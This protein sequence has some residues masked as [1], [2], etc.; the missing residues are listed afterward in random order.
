MALI[1]HFSLLRLNI[2]FSTIDLVPQFVRVNIIG[3]RIIM[4]NKKQT[5][6][7]GLLIVNILLIIFFLYN[8]KKNIDH[9]TSEVHMM[10]QELNNAQQHIITSTTNHVE[11]L[12]EES[13]NK[14]DNFT[15]TITEI[16][17]D[18]KTADLKLNFEVQDFSGDGEIIV[19]YKTEKEGKWTELET[20]NLD[21]L[22]YETRFTAQLDG[23]YAFKIVE[24][25]ANSG[26]TQLNTED[27]TKNLYYEFY[28][29]RTYIDSFSFSETKDQFTLGFSIQNN[30]FGLDEYDIKSVSAQIIYKD[31]I[32]LNQDITQLNLGNREE[33]DRHRLAIASG[34]IQSDMVE[35]DGII[36]QDSNNQSMFFELQLDKDDIIKDF[37]DLF[38]FEHNGFSKDRDVSNDFDVA[39][40]I[41]FNNGEVINVDR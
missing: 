19:L 25:S 33:L 32:L 38:T 17:A 36:I 35:N 26:V 18:D 9:V 16:M 7:I 10:R 22:L 4:D 14:I 39:L 31:Q 21:A 5:I 6:I 8:S 11:A 30:T 2:N 27:L 29:H 20:E 41:V 24:K 15:T 40:N 23:N 3:G 13:K 12:L 1:M 28:E 34:Q 37:P